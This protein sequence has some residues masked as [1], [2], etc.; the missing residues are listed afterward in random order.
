MTHATPEPPRVK[1]ICSF[2][3]VTRTRNPPGSTMPCV[4]CNVEDNRTV[5]VTVPEGPGNR[6]TVPPPPLPASPSA[7][8]VISRKRTS[9]TVSCSGCHALASTSCPPPPR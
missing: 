3:H 2:G 7:L 4:R 8:A 1:A 9:T 6:P 5:M